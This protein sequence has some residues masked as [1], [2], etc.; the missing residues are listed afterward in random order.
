[1]TP[2]HAD[3]L[4]ELDAAQARATDGG[5]SF[6]PLPILVLLPIEPVSPV[7]LPEPEPS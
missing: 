2:T 3:T 7:Y 6:R 1:M 4:V 5:R